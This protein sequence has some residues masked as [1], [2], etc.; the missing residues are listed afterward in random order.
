MRKISHVPTACLLV[1]LNIFTIRANNAANRGQPIV[2]Y[3]NAN[4]QGAP[5][6]DKP[7]LVPYNPVCET[8]FVNGKR[9]IANTTNPQ[10]CA[11][12]AQDKAQ[13][14]RQEALNAA[15]QAIKVVESAPSKPEECIRTVS[16]ASQEC[17]KSKI[18]K[19]SHVLPKYVV[20]SNSNK[21]DIFDKGKKVFTGVR[22]QSHYTKKPIKPKPSKFVKEYNN[23]VV[24]NELGDVIATKTPKEKKKGGCICPMPGSNIVP[25]T[26]E[27]LISECI[28]QDCSPNGIITSILNNATV[29]PAGN[30]NDPNKPT[31]D[32]KD[33][34]ADDKK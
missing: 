15:V 3:T 1:V 4:G 17:L 23:V 10:E 16:N 22:I 30:E 33:K 18:T 8:K 2:L 20:A 25:P 11:K 12:K 27:K 28:K 31:R 6:V 24:F 14:K 13:L 9:V 34:A 7:V 19:N 21:V 5:V 32:S 29:E 26:S